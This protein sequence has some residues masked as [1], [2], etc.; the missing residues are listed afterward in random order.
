VRALAKNPTP[1]IYCPHRQTFALIEDRVLQLRPCY[2]DAEAAQV[3]KQIEAFRAA[4]NAIRLRLAVP[5][6]D[7]KSN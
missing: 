5:P 1:A 6:D 7:E 2:S 3:H 4:E